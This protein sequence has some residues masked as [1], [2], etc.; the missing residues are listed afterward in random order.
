M[1][2]DLSLLCL[3]RNLAV[4]PQPYCQYACCAEIQ[5]T[6]HAG[7]SNR[8]VVRDAE[9]V[10]TQKKN[11]VAATAEPG[12]TCGRLLPYS[13]Q[14]P[15]QVTFNPVTTTHRKPLAPRFKSCLHT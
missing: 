3:R 1:H 12:N 2:A 8:A 4:N 11:R 9:K 7:C 10:T 13:K 14:K 5:E 6:T 15:M